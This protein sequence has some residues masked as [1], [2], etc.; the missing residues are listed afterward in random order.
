MPDPLPLSS[1]DSVYENWC[2]C[3]ATG[4]SCVKVNPQLPFDEDR[5]GDVLKD[6]AAP[7]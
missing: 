1:A 2:A 7:G 5:V 6:S 4:H 3:E